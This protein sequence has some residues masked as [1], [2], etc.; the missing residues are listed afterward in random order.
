MASSGM[1][2]CASSRGI[3][4]VHS[5]CSFTQKDGS[6]QGALFLGVLL[7]VVCWAK[8]RVMTVFHSSSKIRCDAM[9][10]GEQGTVVCP[11][12]L[13]NA[14]LRDSSPHDYTTT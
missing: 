3:F 1:P 6:F 8:H 10:C 4:R 7:G 2:V 12:M 11:S 5:S 9:P 13:R 14:E